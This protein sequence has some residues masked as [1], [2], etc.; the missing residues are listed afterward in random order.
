MLSI[1]AVASS[2][3]RRLW[4]GNWK[5]GRRV[6]F[7]GGASA[8]NNSFAP[9]ADDFAD[10]VPGLLQRLQQANGFRQGRSG[11]HED[12]PDPK[13]E[14]AAPVV[15]WNVANFAKQLE[16]RKDRPGPEIDADAQTLRKNARSVLRDAASSYVSRA[17]EQAGIV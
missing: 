14:S 13:V 17:F 9:G 3:Q 7:P 5:L 12:H 2:Q 11:D 8:V 10:F 15:D 6:G 4:R 1:Q 16:D